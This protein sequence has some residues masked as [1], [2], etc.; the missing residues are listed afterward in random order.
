MTGR[1]LKAERD[2]VL[3]VN[4]GT[5]V[6]EVH[7]MMDSQ[8]SVQSAPPDKQKPTLEKVDYLPEEKKKE[9][10]MDT[11]K[12]MHKFLQKRTVKS[13]RTAERQNPPHPWAVSLCSP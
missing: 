6:G 5:V 13:T 9:W 3:A 11:S 7:L 8:H 4:R 2:R 12:Y 1:L 10:K